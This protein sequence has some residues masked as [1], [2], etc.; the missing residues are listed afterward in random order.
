MVLESLDNFTLVEG[1]PSGLEFFTNEEYDAYKTAFDKARIEFLKLYGY[2]EEKATKVS[3]DIDEFAKIIQAK[4]ASINEL[5]GN[6]ASYFKL[7][8]KSEINEFF[9]NLPI[10]KLLSKYNVSDYE[11]FAIIDEGHLRE[12]DNYYTEEHLP[13]M[14]EILKVLIL[15]KVVALNS[16]PEYANVFA[17][18]YKALS[19]ENVTGQQI[20]TYYEKVVLKPD[21]MGSY[22]NIKYDEKYFSETEKLEIVELIDKIKAHYKEVITSSTWMSEETKQEAIKKL[23]NLTTNVGFV[24]RY[25][26]TVNVQLIKKDEGGTLFGNYILLRQDEASKIATKV[27]EKYYLEVNQF[28]VNAYYNPTD[29]SI[30]FPSAFREVYRNISDKYEIYGYAGMVIAHEMSHAFD[31]TGALYDEYGNLKNWWTEED[32]AKFD[33]LKQSIIDYYSNYSVLGVKV[34]GEKTVSENIADL[35]AVKT[36]LSIMESENATKEDYVKFFEA[37]TKLW[38]QK[39]TKEELEL[40]SLSDNHSPNKIRV[41][42]VFSSM[43]KFYEVYD[44]KETD[45]MYVAKENRVSLW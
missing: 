40:Q 10:D 24:Q 13:V 11:H 1:N 3:N 4:S 21:L 35:G 26:D 34:D 2:D 27:N 33:E 17:D 9:N 12:L 22:L 31:K 19:G 32:K 39:I 20:L 16:T 15:E 28:M 29:N 43:D 30:N 7:Y 6:L 36:I 44:I 23:D 42:A 25:D 37:L 8:S 38:N 18:C 14:K 5:R 41:N 45:G